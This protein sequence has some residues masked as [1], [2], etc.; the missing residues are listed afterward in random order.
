MS[1]VFDALHLQAAMLDVLAAAHATPALLAQR[2]QQRLQRLLEAAREGSALYRERIDAPRS[3]WSD[4]AR[5]EPVSRAELMARFDAWVTDPELRLDELR[6]FIADPAR[7]GQV[8]RDRYVV[9]E[10]SGASSMSGVFVQDARA[11][12]VYDALEAVRHRPP[13]RAGGGL[14]SVFGGIDALGLGDRSALVMAGGGHFASVVSFERLRPINPWLAPLMRSFH[15]LSPVAELVAPLND[16]QPTIIATYPTAAALLADEAAAGRLRIA[17]RHVLTGGE[18]LSAAVRARVTEALGAPVRA[19]YGA[20]EFL[21][22]AWECARGHLHVNEDWVLL[23]PVDSQY[24]P[25]PPGYASH[26]VLLTNLANLTQP[27]IRYDLGDQ[28]MMPPG[29]C[30][31]GSAMPRIEVEGRRD[32]VL[33]VPARK[34]GETVSLLPLALGTVIEGEGVFDFQLQQRGPSTLAL[35]VPLQGE[36]ARRAIARCR[37]ALQQFVQAQGAQPIS[38]VG[39]PNCALPRG[40]SGKAC[41]MA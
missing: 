41:R 14:M 17:P 10:S 19:S 1:A 25:V 8:W 34:P 36:A 40:R 39:E 11:M 18:H 38:V 22:I 27:L 13:G 33:R 6:A 32:D 31:C 20:S 23:E 3:R 16:F 29:R 12:A 15:L 26:S 2:Q 37:R 30:P 35:R 24:R 7:V 28:V 5:I 9:W 21:P 4:L